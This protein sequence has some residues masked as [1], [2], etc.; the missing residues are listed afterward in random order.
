MSLQHA[1]DRQRAIYTQGL[2]GKRPVVPF[3]AA[4]LR[5]AARDKLS[6]AAWDYIDGGA[7]DEQTAVANQQ[8]FNAV[9]IRPRMMRSNESC[10]V[11]STLLRTSLPFPMML[12][13]IGALDLVHPRADCMVAEACRNTGIPFVF[14]NQAGASMESCTAA[15]GDTPRWFQL[16]WSK[17][18]ELVL[19]FV[20]RA[21]ACGCQ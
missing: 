18:D 17:S 6:R 5:R 16:Y 7:G 10:D 19:S 2:A 21:E 11:S 3:D 4:G 15:M 14:S 8:A 20:R 1:L 12:A 13:P 9:T